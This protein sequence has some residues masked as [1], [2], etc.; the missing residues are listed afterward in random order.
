MTDD[1]ANH[2][3]LSNVWLR[4]NIPCN[5]FDAGRRPEVSEHDRS[6]QCTACDRVNNSFVLGR[7][8]R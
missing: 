3:C 1:D 8:A 7:E 4:A 2:E 6:T 5:G